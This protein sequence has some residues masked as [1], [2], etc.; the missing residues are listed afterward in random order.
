MY[1][2]PTSEGKTEVLEPVQKM[3]KNIENAPILNE[4]ILI[5]LEEK[6]MSYAGVKKATTL[7]ML[8]P[9]RLN[10]FLC[11]ETK[12]S[13]VCQLFVDGDVC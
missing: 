5:E 11:G 8:L 12:K 2:R 13:Q 10:L 6:K 9:S 1:Q 7:K 3:L 4:S